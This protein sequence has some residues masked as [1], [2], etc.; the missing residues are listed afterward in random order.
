MQNYNFKIVAANSSTKR[1]L[2]EEFFLGGFDFN[3]SVLTLEVNIKGEI[4]LIQ[5]KSIMFIKGVF[6]INCFLS[7]EGGDCS[8]KVVF[9]QLI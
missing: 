1:L 5:V 2:N 9:E 3:G 7:S 4:F 6:A 8:G